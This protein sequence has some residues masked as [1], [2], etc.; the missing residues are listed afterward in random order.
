MLFNS[1]QFIFLFLVPTLAIFYALRSSRWSALSV[2][3]LALASFVFYAV[4][5]LKFAALLILSLVINYALGLRIEASRA[6]SAQ[7]TAN[8]SMLAGVAFN[9]CVLGFFKYTNFFLQ[10]VNDVAA[11]HFNLLHLILPLGI[12][13]YTFQ[14][15]A[16]LVDASRGRVRLQGFA[17]YALF[18]LFFPQLISGPIV[19]F[20]ELAPQFEHDIGRNP[21]RDIAIGLTLFAVGLLKKTGIADTA[22][23]YATPLFNQADAGTPIPFWGAWEASLAYTV[24]LYFDFSGYTD[25]AIGLAR[26]F[27]IRLPLNFQSPHRAGNI[28]DYW[29]R[30]HMTLQ[31]FLVTYVFQ[32]IALPLTRFSVDR[33]L[34]GKADML[35][36]QIAPTLLV[37]LLSGL[38]HGAG[39]TFILW[40]LLHGAYVSVAEVWKRTRKKRGRGK[41][42][43]PGASILLLGAVA[44]TFAAVVVSNVLFRA[45]T[46]AGATLIY[47][48]MLSPW[49]AHVSRDAVPSDTA[50][51]VAIIALGLGLVF[52]TPNIYQIMRRFEPA[53]DFDSWRSLGNPVPA[54]EWR[55]SILSG[56]VV[57]AIFTVGLLFIMRG[58]SEFIYFNF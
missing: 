51:A 16:F 52:F 32:V 9:L 15:I 13:F 34:A 24:Q 3:F 27:G 21:S 23:L 49:S 38:W 37:F 20:R 48:G 46:V 40:G 54:L 2:H 36:T 19:H 41:A 7:R 4:W 6:V 17:K 28:V 57:G 45:R 35:A 18:V 14:K 58:Q 44:L 50:G 31:K 43:A 26:M 11:T 55:P 56:V 33:D 5:S 47:K 29:R 12:S 42:D 8:A 30:W 10:T 25:M 1:Y 22:A 39:W 53:L